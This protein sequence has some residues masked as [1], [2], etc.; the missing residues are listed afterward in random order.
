MAVPTIVSDI[1]LNLDI[2]GSIT[3]HQTLLVEGDRLRFDLRYAQWVRRPLTGDGRE[4]I[5]TVIEK[6]FSICEEILHSYQCNSY[7]TNP[8]IVNHEQTMIVN[9]ISDTLNNIV[10]RKTK[11]IQGLET[12]STFERYTGDPAFKIQMSRFCERM[13]RICK[14][15]ETLQSMIFKPEKHKNEEIVE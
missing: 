3:N 7:I 4:Q 14:W 1:L 8:D 10:T 11:V 13:S 5:K 6:T 9:N 12:L 2:L 15:A